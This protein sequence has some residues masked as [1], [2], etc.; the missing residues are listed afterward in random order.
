MELAGSAVAGAAGRLS[1]R[2]GLSCAGALPA[3]ESRLLS[4][5]APNGVGKPPARERLPEIK[6]RGRPIRSSAGRSTG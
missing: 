3:S 5:R 4:L 6:S 2:L 1:R